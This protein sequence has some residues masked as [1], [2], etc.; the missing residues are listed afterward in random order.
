MSTFTDSEPQIHRVHKYFDAGAHS[1]I[2]CRPDPWYNT[3]AHQCSDALAT[4]VP[5]SDPTCGPTP[6][7]TSV[8]RPMPTASPIPLH[9]SIPMPVH[10]CSDSMSDIW[11]NT[12]DHEC[13]ETDDHVFTHSQPHVLLDTAE[14]E[15]SD[16][17]TTDVPTPCPPF[18]PTVL[19]TSVATPM[20]TVM[21]TPGST[22]VPTP[23]PSSV[24]TPMQQL[25]GLYARHLAQH[26]SPRVL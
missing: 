13:Y 5:I 24:L 2:D 25:Y 20:C 12:A 16:A 4:A 14:H 18:G 3:A 26:R 15:Y 19:P 6:L 23:L 7:P 11:L 17:G 9:T 8:V 10:S 1:H 22:F 21:S